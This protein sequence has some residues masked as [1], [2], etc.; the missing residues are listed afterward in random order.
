MTSNCKSS[1]L[2]KTVSCS[3]FDALRSESL[4]D[5]TLAAD[6]SMLT[7]CGTPFLSRFHCP[8]SC[9]YLAH[10]APRCTNDYQSDS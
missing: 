9:R 6:N 5:F 2:S 8:V 1:A 4:S 7:V 10:F 3:G